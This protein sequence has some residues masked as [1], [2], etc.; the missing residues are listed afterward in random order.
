MSKCLNCGHEIIWGSDF[1]R[2]EIEGWD[3][4]EDDQPKDEK[5]TEDDD[6]VI[7]FCHCPNCNAEIEFWHLSPNEAREHTFPEDVDRNNDGCFA[8]AGGNLMDDDTDNADIIE[9]YE[10]MYSGEDEEDDKTVKVYRCSDCGSRAIYIIPK[11]QE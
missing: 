9:L 6:T 5:L 7:N 4:D 1:M 11:K 3:Y 2:S 10:E 8:C